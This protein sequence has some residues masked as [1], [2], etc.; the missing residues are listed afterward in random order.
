MARRKATPAE[1]AWK[2]RYAKYEAQCHEAAKIEDEAEKAAAFENCNRVYRE[3][4]A[5]P[6]APKPRTEPT[7]EESAFMDIEVFLFLHGQNLP[8]TE[9][10]AWR[11]WL[12]AG[13]TQ[14]PP[15]TRDD[16][17]TRLVEL[18]KWTAPSTPRARPSSRGR[19]RE[20]DPDNDAEIADQWQKS[21]E[22]GIT[23]RDFCDDREL[24]VE[25]FDNLLDRVRKRP[26][27]DSE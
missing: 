6:E 21:K 17:L 12:N 3:L 27:S 14:K 16:E 9:Q 10:Y 11:Q 20:Y 24:R 18:W 26:K 8:K 2:E 25:A 1:D 13:G 5:K 22:A 4:M 7:I 23:K 19:K 15:P